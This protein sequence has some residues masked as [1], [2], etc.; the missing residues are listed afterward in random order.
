M[1]EQA[2]DTDPLL[3]HLDDVITIHA[4]HVEC[5][6]SVNN[7]VKPGLC[8]EVSNYVYNKLKAIIS[9][10]YFW[11]CLLLGQ[12]I[13]VLLCGTAVTSGLLSDNGVH[14]PTAQ[15]FLNY[16]L[17]CLVF[18][19]SLACRGGD[20]SLWYILKTSGWK[21]FIISVAD[22]EANY[23]VVKAY[24]YTTITSVQLLDCFSIVTVLVLSYCVLGV[25][26]HFVNGVGVMTCVLGLIALVL[27]DT[28]TGNNIGGGS[29]K[30]LGDVFCVCGAFLYGVSNVAE[31][32]V[33]K[34]FDRTE[35]LA[36]LGLFGSLI[37]GIQFAFLE[38]HEV[39]NI[40]YSSYKIILFFVGFTIC[41]FALYTCMTVVIQ[42]TSATT[43]NI[44][45]LTADFYTLLFG[46]CLF[47]YQF[48][49]LYFVS[50]FVILFGVA[51]YA[52]KE[53]ENKN[54]NPV[55]K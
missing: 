15:S 22:V 53:P 35:F 21:Y 12:F 10:R 17:L 50:F 2:T 1:N 46:L 20:R 9:T 47:K 28:L 40:D 30:I 29:N 52:T 11:K 44:S 3:K 36:M 6:I 43:V 34:T 32:F 42:K 13:S 14:A 48:H 27:T 25:R 4:E 54:K 39:E 49:V 45:L 7:P 18:T 5:E 51:I 33:V 23:L 31:E 16:V 26:Y 24:S 37:N 8:S 55:S 19:V 38:K 41:Q